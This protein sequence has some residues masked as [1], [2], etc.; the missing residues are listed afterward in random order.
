LQLEH[1]D[2]TDCEA[3]GQECRR[4]EAANVWTEQ[5]E[6]IMWY[7]CYNRKPL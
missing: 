6:G 2:E 3:I 4:F 1:W 7:G 5:D